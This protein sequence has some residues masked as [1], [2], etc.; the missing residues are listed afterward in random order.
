MLFMS[1]VGDCVRVRSRVV[2]RRAVNGGGQAVKYAISYATNGDNQAAPSLTRINA[3]R[4]A[5][6]ERGFHYV[7]AQHRTRHYFIRTNN[8]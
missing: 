3:D 7:Q 2:V 4:S 8:V 6:A 1:R 5:S